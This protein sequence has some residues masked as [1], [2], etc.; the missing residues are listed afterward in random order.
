MSFSRPQ[1][2]LFDLDGLLIETERLILDISIEM[3]KERGQPDGEAFFLGLIG[4]SHDMVTQLMLETFPD[5]DVAGFDAEH[6]Q[7]VQARYDQGIPFKPGAMEL[8]GSLRADG[9]P[10][11]IATNSARASGQNKLNRTGIGE[12]VDDMVGYD[13]VGSPKPAP[14]LYIEAA[15]RVGADPAQC[16][17]FEDSDTGV[18]AAKG[19]GCY[20]IQVPDMLEPQTD[21]ADMIVPTLLEGARARGL[22]A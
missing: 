2:I 15:R 9:F 8:L 16:V 4:K 12:F 21:L 7:R 14:D 17:A 10:I 19:A 18:R 5:M 20:V 22:V 6:Q 1:A 13:D 11:A 3:M